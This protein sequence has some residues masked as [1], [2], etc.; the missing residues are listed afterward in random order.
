MKSS[1]YNWKARQRSGD[2]LKKS[3]K[4]SFQV[5]L[6]ESLFGSSCATCEYDLDSNI[7]V[8]PSRKARLSE[9]SDE[10]V[11]KR[12]KLNAKQRK[13]LLKVVEA[14]EKKA[15]VGYSN[16]STPHV[17][18]SLLCLRESMLEWPCSFQVQSSTGNLDLHS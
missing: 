18:G 3:G 1:R 7:Q 4:A 13:R 2:E 9:D 10:H 12:K 8:L 15:K 16:Y 14:K 17:L 11:V 6:D 5:E